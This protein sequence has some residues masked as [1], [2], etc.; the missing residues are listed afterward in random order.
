MSPQRDMWSALPFGSA[1]F[2]RCDPNVSVRRIE[3]S[4][5][6]RGNSLSG[7]PCLRYVGDSV[8]RGFSFLSVLLVILRLLCCCS[9][10]GSLFYGSRGF[11]QSTSCTV[12]TYFTTRW[13]SCSSLPWRSTFSRLHRPFSDHGHPQALC[14]RVLCFIRVSV[15]P[16]AWPP[17]VPPR[18]VSQP[19]L[20]LR[21]RRCV[22]LRI[23]HV[24]PR[25]VLRFCVGSFPSSS[26]SSCWKRRLRS[27]SSSR[28]SLWLSRCVPFL[29]R[30]ARV[31]WRHAWLGPF[32][33]SAV[34][35]GVVLARRCATPGAVCVRAVRSVARG[36][37]INAV[38]G[39]GL[40]HYDR[41]RG[42]DHSVSPA[43]PVC[44]FPSIV[45]L[46]DEAC[47]NSTGAVLVFG[48]CPLLLL[49]VLLSRQQR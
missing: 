11:A 10:L 29:C 7:D 33:G 6:K 2:C 24:C 48:V 30:Q 27:C 37:T 14:S 20:G 45:A 31:A 44:E 22:S 8:V 36:D 38:H 34:P 1:L 16:G 19:F 15:F 25:T 9:V 32:P 43:A 18:R 21:V 3:A 40:G 17:G 35:G 26:F 5:R 23:S 49:Q 4:F 12:S 39:R 46:V 42:L 47:G 41:C 28:S 13:P